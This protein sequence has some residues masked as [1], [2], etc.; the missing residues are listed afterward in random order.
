MSGSIATSSA[1]DPGH[2][3]VV[4]GGSA[5]IAGPSG[6]VAGLGSTG[7]DQ[8]GVTHPRKRIDT[9]FSDLIAGAGVV[10][11]GICATTEVA[12]NLPM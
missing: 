2:G 9:A 6:V 4:A 11:S 7:V 12:E 3:G 5:V 1:V 8:S 10:R